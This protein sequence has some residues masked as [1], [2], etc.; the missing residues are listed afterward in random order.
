[1][2]R[3]ECDVMLGFLLTPF[4]SVELSISDRLA[5]QQAP[6]IAWLS[7]GL[8]SL[9]V[10]QH[11]VTEYAAMWDFYVIAWDLRTGPGTFTTSTLPS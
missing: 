3:Q 5:I 6:Q 11:R 8:P 2:C 10:P 9:P 4:S 1:M 7:P